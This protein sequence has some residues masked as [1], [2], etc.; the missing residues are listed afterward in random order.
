M[1]EQG[2]MLNHIF[3]KIRDFGM[4]SGD[5]LAQTAAPTFDIS[6]WQ[7]LAALLAGGRVRILPDDV[8]ADPALLLGEVEERGVTI[9]EVVPSMMRALLDE[10]AATSPEARS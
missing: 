6:V 4:G 10:V 7:F 8:V 9:L 5:L 1:I 3:A 2:G